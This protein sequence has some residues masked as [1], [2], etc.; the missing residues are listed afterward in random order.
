MA[1]KLKD[2]LKGVAEKANI[3]DADFEA[4]LA[5]SALNEIE[6]PDTFSNTFNEQFLTRDRAKNDPAIVGEI[7][8]AMNRSA[9]TTFDEKANNFLSMLDQEDQD[10][11][12]ATKETYEKY[13][14]IRAGLKKVL[15]KTGGK[16]SPEE[17]KK[18][19]EE[20]SEKLR[21][22][23]AEY[24]S[25]ITRFKEEQT[26]LITDSLIKQKILAHN[27]GEA[28]APLK[29]S[30]ADLTVNKVRGQFKLALDK[31]QIAVMREVDGTLREVYEGNDKVTIDKVLEKELKQFIAVSNGGNKDGKK[32]TPPKAP[33]KDLNQMTLAEQRQYMAAG[34]GQA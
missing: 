32:D 23:E 8:K 1:V 9:F 25:S 26:N 31:G 2:F 21:T 15:A 33:A 3:K 6:L 22:K 19:E 7:Q 4:V 24:N 30:I 18:V 13:D 11:V 10:K 17:L 16:A 29:E 27:F 14:L 34:G 20:W 12:K 28:F 5:A